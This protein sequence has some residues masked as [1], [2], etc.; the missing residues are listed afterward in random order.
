MSA[1]PGRVLIRR[2]CVLGAHATELPKLTPPEYLRMILARAPKGPALLARWREPR[3]HRHPESIAAPEGPALLAR[4]REPRDHRHPESI[5][6]PE[7][8]ALLARWR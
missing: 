2:T 4:W 3:D 7:G 8:P 6:A 1:P 5:A